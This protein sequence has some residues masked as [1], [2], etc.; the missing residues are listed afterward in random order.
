MARSTNSNEKALDGD[1]F[2][3][4]TD[5]SRFQMSKQMTPLPGSPQSMENNPN[6]VIGFYGMT[7]NTYQFSYGDIALQDDPRTAQV[8]PQPNSGLAQQQVVGRGFNVQTEFIEQPAAQMADVMESGRLGTEA[9]QRG[10][11]PSAMGMIGQGITP[12]GALA[13]N[14]QAPN[15]MPL[16]TQPPEEAAQM[17]SAASTMRRGSRSSKGMRT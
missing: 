7:P 15:T 14:Q 12:G 2:T 6:N 9:M 5:P 1:G 10:L 11:M 8:M 3:K 17:N 16:T 13:E 4:V